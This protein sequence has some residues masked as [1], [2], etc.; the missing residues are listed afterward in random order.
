[1]SASITSLSPKNTVI[2]T[3][4]V[5]IATRLPPNIPPALACD[6]SVLVPPSTKA[7]E[8]LEIIQSPK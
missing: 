2:P 8:I 7:I 5:K 3:R 1:M 4:K 6:E